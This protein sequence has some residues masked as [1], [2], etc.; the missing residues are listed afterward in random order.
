MIERRRNNKE[1]NWRPQQGFLTVKELNIAEETIIKSV[2]ADCY[3]DEIK[4]LKKL[5]GNEDM[6][7]ERHLA[8]ER[9]LS[10]KQQSSLFRLDPFLDERQV[11][12]VGGR[13]R[14]SDTE[15]NVKHPVVL[16]KNSHITQV[17]IRHVH[18]EQGHQGNG[19]T[20]NA[21]RESGYWII[22]GRSTVRHFIAQCVICR[23]CRARR[24]TQ[25][26]SD[27]PKERVTPAAPF[28]Y[29]GMDVFGPFY[30]KEGRKEVKRWGLIFTCLS[31]RAIHL[32]TLNKMDTDSFINGLRR[33]T[34]RRG[35]VRQLYSDQGT[36]FIGA[37]NEFQS[38]LDENAVKSFLLKNDCDLIKFKF[39]VP[40]ASHMGGTWERQIRTV[41]TVLSS[42]LKTQGTQLDDEGL[43]TLFVETEN[44]VNSR[45]LTVQNMSEPD[46]EEVISPNHLL[47][48]KSRTVQPPPGVFLPPDV[49][50]RK[51]WRRVQCLSEQFWRTWHKEYCHLL[52]KRQKWIKPERNSKVGDIVLLCDEDLPRISWP[53]AKIVKVYPSTDGLV[54]KVQILLTR[55]NRRS[56]LDRPIHKLILIQEASPG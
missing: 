47:T 29:T 38:T 21:L 54:R 37:K 53:L 10:I 24:Q 32:E 26:M 50:S 1:H 36:N 45:P 30:V 14:Q 15:Y 11:I 22:G 9:N 12:R 18:E 7:S 31:S 33:F 44:I 41:R 3:T 46:S 8:R 48:L 20:L 49:Y 52:T 4:T 2:Q 19:I 34:C 43:R 16:P 6:F 56:Y 5:D 42:L 40:S 39:N 17:I 27:L 51:R 25:K 28:T 35:K 55:N 13:L 23:K